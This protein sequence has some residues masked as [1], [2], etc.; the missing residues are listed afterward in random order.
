MIVHAQVP[1]LSKPTTC[2]DMAEVPG[3][4]FRFHGV[5][6]WGMFVCVCVCVCVR[7]RACVLCLFL[8][9]SADFPFLCGGGNLESEEENEEVWKTQLGF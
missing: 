2:K 3:L 9:L 8:Y 5:L 4:R 1:L 6:F 7:T